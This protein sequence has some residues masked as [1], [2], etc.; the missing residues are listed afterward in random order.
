VFIDGVKVATLRGER[1]TEEF[2]GMIE[3]YVAT[4]YPVIGGSGPV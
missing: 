2:V 1:I 4:K 3:Q